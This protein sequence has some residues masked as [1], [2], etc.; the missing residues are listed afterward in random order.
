MSQ[1]YHLAYTSRVWLMLMLCTMVMALP[2]CSDENQGRNDQQSTASTKQLSTTVAGHGTEAQFTGD[3][4]ISHNSAPAGKAKFI[5][6]I[7][8]NEHVDKPRYV[9]ADEAPSCKLGLGAKSERADDQFRWV[10]R[11]TPKGYEDHNRQFRLVIMNQDEI[12]EFIRP[13][14][15]SSHSS[16]EFRVDLSRDIHKNGRETTKYLCADGAKWGQTVARDV[17]GDSG[18]NEALPVK[19]WINQN[20]KGRII[21]GIKPEGLRSQSFEINYHLDCDVNEWWRQVGGGVVGGTTQ[22]LN[23]L[24][25]GIFDVNK[26]QDALTRSGC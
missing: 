23:G 14:R 21:I 13:Q 16:V 19:D 24:I 9:Q 1:R 25:G 26:T 6:R 8:K 4:D 10:V 17:R 15:S 18:C 11:F 22:F 7:I 20:K 5:C 2:S 12:P 3:G